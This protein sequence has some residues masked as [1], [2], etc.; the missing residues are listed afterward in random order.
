MS[1]DEIPLFAGL[2]AGELDRVTHFMAPFSAP[3]D[4]VLFR[5]GEE[6]DRVFVIDVG[7]V[8]VRVERAGGAI[9]TLAT[10]GPTELLGEMAL[11][12]GSRRSG[13]AV[14]REPTAGWILH[15]SGL[16]MLRLDAGA[17]AVELIARLTELQ[18]QRLRG[19]YEAI[20]AELADDDHEEL[21]TAPCDAP[22][23]AAPGV[24]TPDYVA[25]LLCFRHFDDARQIETAL[26]GLSPV[27]LPARAFAMAP[28]VVPAELLLVLRGALDVSIRHREKAQRVR[29]A[30]PGRF[31]GHPGAM[32][33][34]PSPLAAHAR[35]RVV[36]LPI[37][38]ARVLSMMRD[39]SAP[40]RRFAAGLAEDIGRALR[41]AERPIARTVEAVAVARV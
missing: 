31:V 13:T 17:G 20:S 8:E 25:S 41:Q 5:E 39:P 27:E 15:R 2:A 12:G 1:L 21:A 19:R 9:G 40:A 30:G 38:R 34:K 28:G 18:M 23:P 36:L 7:S 11:L 26:A 24:V 14:T 33:G 32:D 37:S 10:V 6:G 4:E 35:E 16:D 29:L 3:A 22:T